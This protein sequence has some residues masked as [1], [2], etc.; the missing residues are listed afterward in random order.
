MGYVSHNQT[1]YIYI[2]WNAKD[3]ISWPRKARHFEAG[4]SAKWPDQNLMVWS[5][6]S[7]YHW[8]GLRENLQEKPILNGKIYGFL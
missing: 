7:S 1:V 5:S 3:P 6:L 8:I 2:Y 4:D